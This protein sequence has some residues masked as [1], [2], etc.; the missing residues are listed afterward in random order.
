M[1]LVK[2]LPPCFYIIDR[3]PC[4]VMMRVL[5]RLPA[6]SGVLLRA[7]QAPDRAR[8]AHRL[9]AITKARSLV[10]LVAGDAVLARACGAQ[11]AHW[12]Q[13][14]LERR[15]GM[16]E[17]RGG[18]AGKTRVSAGLGKRAGGRA[19]WIMTAAAHDHRALAQAWRLGCDA[20]L[21][22]PVF[23]TSS[24][25][26]A[27]IL[28]PHLLARMISRSRLPVYALGGINSQSIRRLPP[29][30]SGI[31]AISGF[32]DDRFCHLTARRPQSRG[33]QKSN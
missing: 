9:A 33:R 17:K 20:V 5:L 21:C 28:G 1:A 31:A 27:K 12:P 14:L 30:V 3:E 22:S 19:G 10:L 2:A 18:I 13:W 11:G 29:G 24:H 4:P 16:L 6:G 25:P 32:H 26:G 15:G 7:Y 23:A 8:L